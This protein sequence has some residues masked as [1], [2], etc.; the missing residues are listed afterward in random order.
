MD[1]VSLSKSVLV[2]SQCQICMGKKRGGIIC[3]ALSSSIY[4]TK[5]TLEECNLIGQ[6]SGLL[7]KNHQFEFYKSQGH[8]KLTQ[9]LTLELVRLVDV[10]VS[11]PEHSHTLIKGKK[12]QEKKVRR[13]LLFHQNSTLAIFLQ[14][15]LALVHFLPKILIWI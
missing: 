10:R 15:Q 8:W 4:E 11:W 7:F 3:I 2:E 14:V 9:L 12:I 1:V 5:N 6:V 13:Y